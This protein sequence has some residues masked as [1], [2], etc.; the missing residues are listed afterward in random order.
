MTPKYPASFPPSEKKDELEA[1]ESRFTDE[2]ISD[3]SGT[4]S[5]SDSA[6]APA[7]LSNPFW[8]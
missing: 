5:S 3:N 7:G 6:L 2:K 4:E 1:A 8:N